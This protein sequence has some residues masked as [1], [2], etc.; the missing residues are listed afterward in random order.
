MPRPS[1]KAIEAGPSHGSIKTAVVA[2]EVLLLLGIDSCFSHASGIIMQIG[3]GEI[4]AGLVEKLDRVVESR[5]VAL[6]VVDDRQ[7]L[8]DVVAEQR[9]L[10]R[11]APARSSS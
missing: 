9:R 8:L 4:A 7:E 3:V 5:G 2:V 11:A 1:L 10:E 6:A